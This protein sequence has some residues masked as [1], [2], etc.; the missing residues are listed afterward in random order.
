MF[1][2]AALLLAAVSPP[3][4]GNMYDLLQPRHLRPAGCTL[5]CARWDALAADGSTAN[6]SLVDRNWGGGSPPVGAGRSCA[7]QG[8]VQ[9]DEWPGE[10]IHGQG[11]AGVGS[12]GAF[13]YCSHAATHNSSSPTP[14]PQWGTCEPPTLTPEQINLQWAAPTTIV[15]GF[16]TF[17]DVAN[18]RPN[19]SALPPIAEVRLASSGGNGG[20]RREA[21]GVTTEYATAAAP[22]NP[23]GRE[24]ET[25]LPERIYAMH[26][27][28]LQ[29]RQ[30]R[31]RYHYRVRSGTVGAVWS[32]THSFRAP[33]SSGATRFTMFGD[34]GVYSWNNLCAAKPS[35]TVCSRTRIRIASPH[36]PAWS[37]ILCFS[38]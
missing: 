20:A 23:F 9:P 29:S 19:A 18:P 25:K 16:V 30:Q 10:T 36:G 8:M 32:D 1:R 33:Y 28:R 12:M 7:Q 13:C 6:Q 26:F 38:A 15:I 17:G 37:E 24:H 11:G 22:Y 5:G 4:S 21:K 31:A 2:R 14:I 35:R 27:V 34:M 3:V